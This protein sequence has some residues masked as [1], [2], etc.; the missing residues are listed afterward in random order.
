[1]K[2]RR[3]G[4][5]SLISGPPLPCAECGWCAPDFRGRHLGRGEPIF[6]LTILMAFTRTQ[7]RA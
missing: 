7:Q 2:V 1:M 5:H 6:G 4:P 3:K